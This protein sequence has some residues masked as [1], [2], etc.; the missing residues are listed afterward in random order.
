MAKRAAIEE[1]VLNAVIAA[2]TMTLVKWTGYAFQAVDH[3]RLMETM[4]PYNR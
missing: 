2:E 4:K 3:G 1:A